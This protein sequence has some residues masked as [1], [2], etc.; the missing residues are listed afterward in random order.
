MH[1]VR[2]HA[3][4]LLE[5]SLIEFDA[6][7]RANVDLGQPSSDPVGIELFVPRAVQRV[8]Y[9]ETLAVEADSDQ[10]AHFIEEFGLFLNWEDSQVSIS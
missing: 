1:L 8:G 9:G 5:S 3:V 7:I 10:W 4:E 2:T 6:A